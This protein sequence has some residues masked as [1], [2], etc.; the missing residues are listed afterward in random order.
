MEVPSTILLNQLAENL[1]KGTP[2]Q[3]SSHPIEHENHQN[4]HSWENLRVFGWAAL[5]YI[6]KYP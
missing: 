5:P 4:L 2:Q 1:D 6:P 3:I